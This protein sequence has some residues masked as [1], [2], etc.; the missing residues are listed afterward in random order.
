MKKKLVASGI[1]LAAICCT[2]AYATHV[3]GAMALLQNAFN[4]GSSAA[5]ENPSKKIP[6][7]KNLQLAP[8]EIERAMSVAPQQGQKS[9]K[10]ASAE[11]GS[12]EEVIV[13]LWETADEIVALNEG[14]SFD[15]ATNTI[16]LPG[17]AEQTFQRFTG[18][19]AAYYD[20]KWYIAAG[21]T[22]QLTGTLSSN[23]NATVYPCITYYDANKN[24]N[25]ILSD[26]IVSLN[27]E[28]GY[29]AD[30]NVS[31]TPY[32][33]GYPLSIA[34]IIENS[35][36]DT[37]ISCSNNQFFYSFET[38]IA[39]EWSSENDLPGLGLNNLDHGRYTV[40]C[41]D[42]E[43]TLGIFYNGNQLFVTGI[44]TTAEEVTLPSNITI[45]GN[46]MPISHFGLYDTTM[47]WSGAYYLTTLDI[48]SVS[49]LHETFDGSAI[50]DLYVGKNTGISEESSKMYD[51]YL[52]IPYTADRDN[53]DFYG[54]KRVLVGDEQPYYPVAN[55]SS[56]VIAG[57]EEGDYF[58]IS[59]Y[60]NYYVITEIFTNKESVVLPF[61][62]PYDGG[63]YYIRYLGNGRSY[64][65]CQNA[66]SLKSVTIPVSYFGLR[67]PWSYN[68]IVELHMQG[69]VIPTDWD[70]NSEMT[71]YVGNQAYYDNYKN[72]YNWKNASIVPE[73]W[74]FEWITVNVE[75]KGEFAETYL[76]LE[77]GRN[78][79][80]YENVTK[81]KV[82]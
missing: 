62:T 73:G 33:E 8:G 5:I 45:E 43:T 72:N 80:E 21:Q 59:L 63:R 56:W 18:I 58:G 79:I 47:D 10:K 23:G 39:Q 67:L 65:L 11:K 53:Y 35:D 64:N 76:I 14:G 77:Y 31:A 61:D 38:L 24:A 50:T 34:F 1:F 2:I 28:N 44:N 42:N 68:P 16:T 19:D 15:A 49:Y 54:F 20:Y 78:I 51:M 46:S 32:Q 4:G 41:E 26:T 71:V 29:T 3:D 25:Y 66:P 82:Y 69:D 75:K 57:E 12:V 52:H 48:S 9:P 37:I 60:D 7:N 6:L 22:Y 13:N 17:S 30:F 74:D 55:N 40:T 27:E 70:L 36:E 81:C